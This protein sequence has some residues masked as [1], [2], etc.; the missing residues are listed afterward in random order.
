MKKQMIAIAIL[1]AAVCLTG[2]SININDDTVNAAKD[3][4]A[5]VLDETDIT[6][7]GQPV[8]VSVD[9]EGN[10]SVNVG[11]AA[12]AKP[13][14]NLF[15]GY[16]LGDTAVKAKPDAN[17]E[18]LITIPDATQIGVQES[19]T[20]GW[21]MTEFQNQ[22]GYIAADSVKDIPPYDPALGGDN[23]RGGYIAADSASVKLMSGTHPYAEVLAEIP[24]STQI[25]YYAVPNDAEWCVVNFQEHVGYVKAGCIKDIES[26][27]AG[28]GIGSVPAIVGEWRYQEQDMQ[29][30][31]V[32]EDAGYVTVDADGTYIYQPKDGSLRKR[33]TVAVAYDE[34]PDGS[35]TAYYAFTDAESGAFWIGTDSCDPNGKGAFYIGNGG[36]ARLFPRE[37]R[38][39]DFGDYVG[40][41][42]CDRC[43]I[44]IG[45]QGTGYLVTIHWADSAS[46]DNVWSYSC[47]G[48]SDNTG[49]ECT[50]GGTLTHIVTAADGTENRTVVYSDGDASFR[51]RGGRLFWSDGKENKGME[52]GF[53]KIG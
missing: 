5:S 26:Y 53:E 12:A 35:S 50:E 10:V 28:I 52:M 13:G 18:T 9:S 17:S 4:A 51:C 2:C 20:A 43:T 39:D 46:E 1:G 19:G 37:P 11:Q 21:F 45:E 8:D 14:D 32:Y 41:W 27:D 33:G 31:G 47:S 22:T 29:T 49:L 7:N 34:H 24:N 38:Y 40:I 44:Q 16:V 42:Q 25:N 15:G 48:M 30:A 36:T 23:V 6:V 3:L